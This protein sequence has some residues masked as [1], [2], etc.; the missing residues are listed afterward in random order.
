V[1]IETFDLVG[2]LAELN[3][4]EE[5]AYGTRLVPMQRSAR[6]IFVLLFLSLN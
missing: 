5:A 6:A 4:A 2:E 1:I 3:S